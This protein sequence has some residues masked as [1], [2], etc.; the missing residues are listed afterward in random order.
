M[1]D[2]RHYPYQ[3]FTWGFSGW[4][5]SHRITRFIWR[6]GSGSHS[7]CF[8]LI[9]GVA[10]TAA[11]KYT[12]PGIFTFMKGIANHRVHDLG[13]Y[14]H[15]YTHTKGSGDWRWRST[16][17]Q[18]N[19]PLNR[20][21]FFFGLPHCKAHSQS[22]LLWPIRGVFMVGWLVGVDIARN[23]RLTKKRKI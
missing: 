3:L 12:I 15:I 19:I 9:L 6:P 5:R 13:G 22:Y 8:D 21:F 17:L 16:S 20:S 23:M 7:L 14:M 10:N 1:P 11:G 18:G 2:A 4:I